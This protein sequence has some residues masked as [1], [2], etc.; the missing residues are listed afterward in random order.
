MKVIIAIIPPDRLVSVKSEL[1]KIEVFRLSVLDVQGFGSN[2]PVTTHTQSRESELMLSRRV[3]L[4]IGVNDNFLEPT[5]EAIQR[6][7]KDENGNSTIEGKIFILPMLD[8]IRIR[9]G[10]RGPEAI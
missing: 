4:F 8:C 1:A 3:Q 7:T 2:N 9:T 10:E 6:G 5:I